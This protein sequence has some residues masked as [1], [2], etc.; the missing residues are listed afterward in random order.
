MKKLLNLLVTLLFSGAAI[1]QQKKAV[2]AND[3][4]NLIANN[5]GILIDVRTPQEFQEG[6]IAGAVNADW[7]NPDV[8]EKQTD[9]L[10]KSKPVYL[11][12]LAGVR[13]EKAAARLVEKGF[14]NVVGLHGGIEEWRKAGKPIEK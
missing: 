12:C 5:K 8:F 2:N 14:K 11:Y 1:S 6:R 10:D 4:E 3:F 7:K 13:S 9:S